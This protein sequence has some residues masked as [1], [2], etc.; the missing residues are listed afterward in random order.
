MT[1][2]TTDL[3]RLE[4]M[5]WIINNAEKY[6]ARWGDH[7]RETFDQCS[8][9]ALAAAA[10]A[11]DAYL[12]TKKG[13]PWGAGT[14]WEQAEYWQLTNNP[15]VKRIW[16]VDPRPWDIAG[17]TALE[18]CKHSEAELLWNRDAGDSPLAPRWSCPVR[19]DGTV[20]TDN[21]DE[22]SDPDEEPEGPPEVPSVSA[23]LTSF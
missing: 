9:Q 18:I 12:F 4:Q 8:Y 3:G 21:S 11:P 22:T 16:R 19:N 17:I 2:L 10:V 23:T 1:S 7:P 15:N 6:K 20:P 5:K 13:V 14:M